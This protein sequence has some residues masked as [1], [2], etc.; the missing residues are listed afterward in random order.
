MKLRP[1]SSSSFSSNLF[2]EMK[3]QVFVEKTGWP[4]FKIKDE[5][6]RIGKDTVQRHIL[7][8]LYSYSL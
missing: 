7:E 2:Q 5:Y 3:R 4:I 6:I 1:E 8:T